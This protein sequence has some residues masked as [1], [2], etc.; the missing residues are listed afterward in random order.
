MAYTHKHWAEKRHRWSKMTNLQNGLAISAENFDRQCPD[1]RL[2]NW[3]VA[4]LREWCA[5][6]GTEMPEIPDRTLDAFIRIV[7]RPP[8]TV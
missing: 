5:E 7:G 4:E 2:S 8:E 1:R 3:E 6:N